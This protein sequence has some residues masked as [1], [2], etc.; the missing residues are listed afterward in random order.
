VPED[1]VDRGWELGLVQSAIPEPV[2]G[3]GDARS[4]ITGALL[5]EE[6]GYGD[7]RDHARAARPAPGHDPARAARHG[8]A[9]AQWL[10]RF[11]GDDYVAAGGGLL[12]AALGLRPDGPDD[13]SRAPGRRLGDHG[14]KCLVPLA[15]RAD[16]ILVYASTPNGMGAFLVEPGASGLKVGE[17]EHEHGDQG[18]RHLPRRV[19]RRTCAAGEPLGGDDTSV[20][21]LVRREPGR[22]RGAGH[23]HRSRG[24]RLCARYAKE[25]RA[26]GVAIGQKQAIAF[27]LADMAIE[28][29]AMRLLAWEAAWKLDRGEPATRECYLAKDYASRVR[30]LGRRQRAPGARRSRLHPRSPRRAAAPKRPRPCSPSM[31]WP[32]S[33]G[34][35]P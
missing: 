18:A 23:R 3:Y 32:S 10:P 20:A 16:V 33:E 9:A 25:R 14:T 22:R 7:C 5:L 34:E 21:P 6:L 1:V 30:A 12:R 19:R 8:R 2:G 35:R 31:A 4:A 24:I 26:F 17:R 29:D 15:D 27:K 28:I 11:A 13:A